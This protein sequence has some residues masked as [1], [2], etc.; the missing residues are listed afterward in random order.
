MD[1]SKNRL[2]LYLNTQTMGFYFGT[3][4]TTINANSLLANEFVVRPTTELDVD[5]TLWIKFQKDGQPEQELVLMQKRRIEPTVE[6]IETETHYL[7]EIE[8]DDVGWEYYVDIPQAV[9]MVAG[10]WQFALAIRV[11]ADLDNIDDFVLVNTTGGDNAV[12]VVKNNIINL[13]GGIAKTFDVAKIWVELQQGK[14]NAYK[15]E[16]NISLKYNLGDVVDDGNKRFFVCIKQITDVN[17]IQITDRVYWQPLGSVMDVKLNGESIVDTNGVVALNI[18]NLQ[19]IFDIKTTE[20]QTINNTIYYGI[21]IENT[22]TAFE[23]YKD[24]KQVLV[25]N[26]L[27][28]DKIFIACGTEHGES[29]QVRKLSGNLLNNGLSGEWTEIRSGRYVVMDGLLQIR[30]E[31]EGKTYTVFV[32]H[33]AGQFSISSFVIHEFEN[34]DV[35]YLFVRIT[36]DGQI[37]LCRRSFAENS[38]IHL[39]GQLLYRRVGTL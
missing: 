30:F 38:T 24:G 10:E 35:Y 13:D 14:Y 34:G 17:I 33:R 31:T 29:L 25:Q 5:E 1:R 23:V 4:L 26:I 9:M 7:T 39:G 11:V 15:G 22:D 6:E 32:E 2:I 16:H 12:F 18:D 3:G 37:L 19:S 27:V 21:Y 8:K 36:G 20:S 28:G